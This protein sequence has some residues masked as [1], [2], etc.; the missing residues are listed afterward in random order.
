MLSIAYAEN[1]K[2]DKT[3]KILARIHKKRGRS[4][5]LDARGGR[6]HSTRGGRRRHD[7]ALGHRAQGFRAVLGHREQVAAA[8]RRLAA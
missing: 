8:H 5:V 1:P 2:G 6:T 4:R 3:K 7:C